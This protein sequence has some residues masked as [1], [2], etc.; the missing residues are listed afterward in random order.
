MAFRDD[1][2]FSFAEIYFTLILDVGYGYNVFSD[3]RRIDGVY[4]AVELVFYIVA[5][6][7]GINIHKVV[8]ADPNPR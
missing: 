5:S 8:D 6:S 2:D 4:L 3:R 1:D 7:S